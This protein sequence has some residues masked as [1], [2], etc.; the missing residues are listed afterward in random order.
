MPPKSSRPAAPR[1]VRKVFGIIVFPLIITGEMMVGASNGGC[2][3]DSTSIPRALSSCQN[4]PATPATPKPVERTKGECDRDNGQLTPMH[5]RDQHRAEQQ[6]K[7]REEH[8]GGQR[9]CAPF[10]CLPL[11]TRGGGANQ[12]FIDNPATAGKNAVPRK[13]PG[14]GNQIRHTATTYN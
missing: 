11:H 12:P 9:K 6:C 5:S 1:P 14:D 2:C 10:R 7:R 8:S 13:P 3:H 4:L